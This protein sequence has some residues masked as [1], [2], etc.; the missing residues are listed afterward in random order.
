MRQAGRYLPEYRLLKDKAGGFLKICT[1][2]ELA[3][4]ITLQP[5]QR[6]PFDAAILFSDILTPILHTNIGIEFAPG[7]MVSF[8]IKNKSDLTRLTPLT[9]EKNVS[10]VREAITII[11]KKS[12]SH[13]PLIGFSG[14][15]FTIACYITKHK[16]EKDFSCL[17]KMVYQDKETAVA[18]LEKLTENTI[19]YLQYQIQS[20]VDIIQIFDTWAGELCLT[21]YQYFVLPYIQNIIQS[22]KKITSLPIIYYIKGAEHLIN[23][24][25]QTQ[26]DVISI[27]WRMD[28]KMVKKNIGDKVALQGN[29]DPYILFASQ[30]V[31]QHKVHS[32]LQCFSKNEG[33]FVFNLG[34]GIHKDTPLENV[35]FLIDCVHNY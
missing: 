5:I 9:P 17:R 24:L 15:P 10:F 6:F 25:P 14:S 13:I 35:K 18:L 32:I 30:E 7:P 26:A 34:H 12:P 31:I 1:T 11:K 16:T 27:D 29:L 2:P 19:Q 20:G 23:I 28:I 4:E 22:I 3:A 33:G 21:E 8:P